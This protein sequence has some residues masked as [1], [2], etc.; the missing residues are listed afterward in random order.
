MKIEDLTLD[1]EQ[2]VE[3]NGLIEEVFK[4]VLHRFGEGNTAPNGESL[5]LQ[6]EQFAGGRWFRDRGDGVQHLW[7]ARSGHQAARFA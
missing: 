3:V 1:I 2:S 5:Q 4:S 6:I 7:G